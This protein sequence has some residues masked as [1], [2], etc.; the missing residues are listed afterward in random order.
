M[1]QI[2]QCQSRDEESAALY[3]RSL[4]NYLKTIGGNHHR[5]GHVLVKIAE[6]EARVGHVALGRVCR[7]KHNIRYDCLLRNSDLYN[8][9]ITVFSSHSHYDPELARTTFKKAELH[10]QQDDHKG[11]SRLF[12]DAQILYRKVVGSSIDLGRELD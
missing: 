2:R 1:G 6:H 10:R 8:K 4:E 9:A 7:F 12:G 3:N 11:A 5:T